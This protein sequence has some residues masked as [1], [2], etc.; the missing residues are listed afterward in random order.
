[1]VRHEDLRSAQAAREMRVSVWELQIDAAAIADYSTPKHAADKGFEWESL[2]DDSWDACQEEGRRILRAGGQGV[3]A[4]SAALSQG[5]AL[6]LFGPRTEIAW[7][8]EPSV[9]AQIPARK[10]LHGAPGENLVEDTRFFGEPYPRVE[11]TP[12]EQLVLID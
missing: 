11:P 4:P 7:G 9:S 2:V 8:F 1:M 10:I 5:V 12:A 3:L 6:T